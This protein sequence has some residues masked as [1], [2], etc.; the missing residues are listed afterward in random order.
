MP[1]PKGLST[2]DRAMAIPAHRHSLRIRPPWQS[3]HAKDLYFEAA[4]LATPLQSR[5]PSVRLP[6]QTLALTSPAGRPPEAPGCIGNTQAITWG[7]QSLPRKKAQA[8]RT[9]GLASVSGTSIN[10][11][12]RRPADQ[13][14]ASA[15]VAPKSTDR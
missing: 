6:A 14:I 12:A 8:L 1:I 13:G 9:Q 5:G 2:N 11:S 15:A 3:D 7:I 4:A 10:H